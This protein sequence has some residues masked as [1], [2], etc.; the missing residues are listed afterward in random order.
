MNKIL[1][2]DDDAIIRTLLVRLLKKIKKDFQIMT[3]AD[4]CTA[5]EVLKE[6]SV[7]LVLTDYKMPGMDGLETFA[8]MKKLYPNLPVIMMSGFMGKKLSKAFLHA[9]G[10]GFIQKPFR[11]GE[12][13][14][15]V[16]S[17]LEEKRETC[18]RSLS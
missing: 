6:T 16:Q 14:L 7:D 1:I 2:V 3:A 5:L 18:E 10:A 17:V 8:E 15:K 12:L 9:G 4:G 13:N 11:P